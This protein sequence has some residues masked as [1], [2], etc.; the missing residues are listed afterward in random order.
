MVGQER[1][2]R[3]TR[4]PYGRRRSRHRKRS[5]TTRGVAMH[6][7]MT[8]VQPSGLPLLVSKSP[9]SAMCVQCSRS[10]GGE[11]AYPGGPG[12]YIYYPPVS[13]WPKLMPNSDPDVIAG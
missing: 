6:T 12:H 13:D 10:A 5:P 2:D 4:S 11:P 8:I 9:V 1:G 3:D 7:A